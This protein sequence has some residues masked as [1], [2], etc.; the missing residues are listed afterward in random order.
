MLD[1]RN[2]WRGV[3][4][5]VVG[6]LFS[7][8]GTACHHG[9]GAGKGRPPAVGSTTT[10]PNTGDY[11]ASS[12]GTN[13]GNGR[14][15]QPIDSYGGT[16]GNLSDPSAT[17]GEGGPLA[18][19]RFDLDSSAL[20]PASIQ[21]LAAHAAWLK[22]HKGHVTIEG[23]CDERGTVEYNLALGEQRAKAVYDHLTELGVPTAQMQTVS[24]GKERPLDTDHTE[25]AFAKNRRAHFAVQ[26]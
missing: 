5:V 2:S 19:I 20:T 17:T 15:I 21:T 23:H 13:P 1:M 6:L 7:F 22:D 4:A 18:D 24:L 11:G 14:D 9:G 3:S 8:A 25:E 26:N 10:A 16:S 12:R